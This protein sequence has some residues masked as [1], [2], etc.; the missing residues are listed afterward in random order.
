MRS[1][2][3]VEAIHELKLVCNSG[4]EEISGSPG[5]YLPGGCD[6]LRVR[7]DQVAEGPL[8]GYLLLSIDGSYLIDGPYV[9]TQAAM[10]AQDRRVHHGGE[11]EG[12]KALN[13]VPPRRRVAVLSKALVV[14]TV[15]LGDLSRLMIA[16][17]QSDVARILNLQA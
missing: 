10:H 16:P 5:R 13:A 12:V 17:E 14:E 9:G 15:D 7:P 1:C 4:P 11:G 2:Y 8:V 3:Q 6:V